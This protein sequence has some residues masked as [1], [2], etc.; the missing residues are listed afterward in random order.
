MWCGDSKP[1][2]LVLHNILTHN[3]D[4]AEY[5]S[6]YLE[7][8]KVMDHNGNSEGQILK[9]INISSR[10]IKSLRPEKKKERSNLWQKNLSLS[11]LNLKEGVERILKNNHESFYLEY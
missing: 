11:G 7:E 8:G 1:P 3:F 2:N 6:G 5:V 4:G 9:D 10:V